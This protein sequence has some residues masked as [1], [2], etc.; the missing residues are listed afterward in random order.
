VSDSVTRTGSLLVLKDHGGELLVRVYLE[1]EGWYDESWGAVARV[2][3]SYVGL[4]ST[5][6]DIR[7][8]ISRYEKSPQKVFIWIEAV[9]P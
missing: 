6:I 8:G 2:I 4:R 1:S 3:N 9:I 5:W 7:S